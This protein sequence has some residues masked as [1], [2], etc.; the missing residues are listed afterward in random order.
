MQIVIEIPEKVYSYIK[1]EWEINDGDS[2]L[3][4]VFN[5][6]KN[7]IVLPKGHGRLFDGRDIVNGN[8]EIIGNTI[9]ECEPALEADKEDNNADSD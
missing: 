7:G 8:Y 6:V 2:P 5:G 3:N 1:R 9:Y 4:H